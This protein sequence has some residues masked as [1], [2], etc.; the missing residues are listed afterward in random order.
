MRFE[1]AHF[2]LALTEKIFSDFA[3]IDC[4]AIISPRNNV[5]TSRKLLCAYQII[6]HPIYTFER[7]P[8]TFGFNPCGQLYPTKTRALDTAEIKDHVVRNTHSASSA[9]RP[10]RHRRKMDR[11]RRADRRSVQAA[12][13]RQLRIFLPWTPGRRD[14]K[15]SDGHWHI[16]STRTDCENECGFCHNILHVQKLSDSCTGNIQMGD[17]VLRHELD[18]PVLLSVFESANSLSLWI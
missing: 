18:T 5:R 11:M 15:I 6:F 7:Y 8:K 1:V 13:S 10:R 2:I 4:G 14:H 9:H 3:L 17:D 12:V 16:I